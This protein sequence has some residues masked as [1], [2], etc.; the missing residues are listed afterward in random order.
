MRVGVVQMQAEGLQAAQHRKA[1]RPAA[2]VPKCMPST[3]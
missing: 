1:D 2:I 3:S